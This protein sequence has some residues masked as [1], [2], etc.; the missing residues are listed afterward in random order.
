[1][2]SII[3]C[4]IRPNEAEALRQNIA[5]TIGD[6]PFEMIAYDNRGTGKGIAEVYN[7]CA[8][9]AK[10]DLLCF[11]HED[12][13]FRSE[14]WGR[15]I[16]SKLEEAGTGVIGFAGSTYK[17]AYPTGWLCTRRWGV[18]MHYV[19]GRGEGEHL[20]DDNPDKSYY[21]EVVSLDGLCLF[22]HRRVWE[23]VRF[24]DELLRGFHCYDVDF[25]IATTIAGYRNY[26]CHTQLVKHRSSGAYSY[27]WYHTNLAMHEK[28]SDFLPLYV[29]MPSVRECEDL[30]RRAEAEALRKVMQHGMFEVC[31]WGDIVDYIAR[32]PLKFVSY[33]LFAQTIKYRLRALL[34]E[35]KR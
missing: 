19:Q 2:F 8:A 10:Y 21:S 1:M 29:A 9:R 27:D 6:V 12:I 32:Y 22:V 4:S 15:D 13:E 24:D 26:V 28:W 18:R 20:F 30:E 11:A 14:G 16:A 34:K 7:E 25:T 33:K 3:V 17:S 23:E 35:V 31:S 5:A